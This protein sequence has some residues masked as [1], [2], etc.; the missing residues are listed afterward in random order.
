MPKRRYIPIPAL[1]N[2]PEERMSHCQFYVLL[3]LFLTVTPMAAMDLRVLCSCNVE[4]G[5]RVSAVG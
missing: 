5:A 3:F 1:R 4:V 2:D